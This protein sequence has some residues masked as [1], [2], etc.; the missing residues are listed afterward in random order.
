MREARERA[1][2]QANT[3]VMS[4]HGWRRTRRGPR[5]ATRWVEDLVQLGEIDRAL[6]RSA[7]DVVDVE[8]RRPRGRRRSN[9]GR[10]GDG[11]GRVDA[12]V[13]SR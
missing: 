9:G 7:F 6:A 11:A 5:P 1:A 4:R 2:R 12:L 10:P 13:L 8:R 3:Y